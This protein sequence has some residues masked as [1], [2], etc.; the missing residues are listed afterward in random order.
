MTNSK[1]FIDAYNLTKKYNLGS[2]PTPPHHYV[3]ITGGFVR[4]ML[5]LS[6][7]VFGISYGS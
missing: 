5:A 1:V 3:E 4:A 7:C 2:N 6:V